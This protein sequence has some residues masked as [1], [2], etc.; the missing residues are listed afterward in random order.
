MR[1]HLSVWTELLTEDSI[2]NTLSY[3]Q[4]AVN[5]G[6]N[7]ESHNKKKMASKK[8]AY[9]YGEMGAE[10]KARAVAE[11]G[12]FLQWTVRLDGSKRL[13]G[14]NFCRLRMCP[15]CSWYLARKRTRDLIKVFQEPEHL[16]K[17]RIYITLT[18]KNCQGEDLKDT[19]D[20]MFHALR[21][22]T[23]KKGFLDERILGMVKKLEVT[24]NE[25]TNEYHPHFH[26]LCEVEP[27]YFSDKS[28]YIE[29]DVLQAKWKKFCKLDYDP[30]VSI[31]ACDDCVNA[32]KEIS[33]YTAKDADYT[34]SLETFKIFDEALRNRRLY[35][36]TGSIKKTMARLKM[37]EDSI[38]DKTDSEQTV[39]D[40]PDILTF[41]LRW[42]VNIYKIEVKKLEAGEN[43]NA[44]A[45]MA[46]LGEYEAEAG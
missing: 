16:G 42:H 39:P 43:L 40:N 32:V 24:Y 1:Q 3:N 7:I 18:V 46:L 4:L 45:G 25:E 14:A 23:K 29:H 41:T 21:S 19:I 10:K 37:D 38:D 15:M 26:L 34:Y 13:S 12:N 20:T 36:P 22:M 5:I 44:V 31:E 2:M 8:V 30:I 33:K 11:C 6:I 35:T 28:L 17:R 27:S 9:Y